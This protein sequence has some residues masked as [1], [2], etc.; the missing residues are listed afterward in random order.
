MALFR[1]KKILQIFTD[2]KPED[3]ADDFDMIFL[4]IDNTMTQP[5]VGMQDE[6]NRAFILDLLRHGFKVVIL[7]NNNEKRVTDFIDDLD[8]TYKHY[9]LK[10]LPFAYWQMCAK[11]HVKPSR[12]IMLGDQLLTDILGANLS[13]CYG[14]YSKQLYEIDTPTTARN[15]KI[16]NLIWRYLL[17]EKV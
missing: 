7:S 16:E 9:A 17:H 15:R 3:Y 10:P 6:R 13:G 11:M 2:F 14:I 1:P 5:D 12:T 4:D 8:I